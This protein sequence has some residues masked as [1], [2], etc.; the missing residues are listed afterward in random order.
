MGV[1]WPVRTSD[2]SV[3]VQKRVLNKNI[4]IILEKKGSNSGKFHF[5]EPPFLYGKYEI[6]ENFVFGFFPET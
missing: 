3:L 6:S 5:F 2:S 1:Y 4:T